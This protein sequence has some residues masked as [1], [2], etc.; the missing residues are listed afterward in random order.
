MCSIDWE[1]NF[2]SPHKLKGLKEKNL[3]EAQQNG[4]PTDALAVNKKTQLENNKIEKWKQ[5]GNKHMLLAGAYLYYFN[6]SI[7]LLFVTNMWRHVIRDP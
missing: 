6:G 4:R 3:K 7:F 5:N 2:S 1:I